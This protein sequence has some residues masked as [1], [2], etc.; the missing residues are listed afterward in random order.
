MRC[1]GREAVSVRIMGPCDN[2]ARKKRVPNSTMPAGLGANSLRLLNLGCGSRHH[3]EWINLDFTA[4]DPDVVAHDLRAPL[5][6]EEAHFDAVYHSHVLE[7]LPKPLAPVFLR[8]CHRV[9]RPGGVLRVAVPDLERI[10]R[11]YLDNL[12]GALAGDA[13]ARDRYDWMM[14]ELCDQMARH[15]S[16][17]EMLAWWKQNPMPAEEFVYER[18]GSEARECI[19]RLREDADRAA[20]QDP[21]GYARDPAAV[22]TF[23]L[24]GEV[25]QWM[26]DRFSLGRLLMETGFRNVAVCAA[27]V[28]A[29]AD[30]NRYLLDIEPDGAV[31]KPDSLF[32][33]GF[34]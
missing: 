9:L 8:E 18:V 16:G 11:L 20:N 12:R 34:K 19:R 2:R 32:M 23:R 5:P 15:A 25:H 21:A 13:L 30:F 17:G 4:H 29:I 3:P 33:E 27:D 22:G 26:Y 1:F 6:F 10:A 31:R 7:H 28:S 14:I 24:S